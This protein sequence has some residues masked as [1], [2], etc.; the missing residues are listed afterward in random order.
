MKTVNWKIYLNKPPQVVY[1]FLSTAKGRKQF[2]AESAE[3]VNGVIHFKFPNGWE[4]LGKIIRQIQNEEFS[5]DYFDSKVTFRL[6][7][8][9]SGTDLEL[10]NEKV[11]EQEFEEVLSGWVSVLMC[12]KAAVD[13][14]VDLRNH[15]SNKTWDQG[16]INN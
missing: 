14:G 16:F 1:Q 6:V 3:E 5:V 8:S 7:A 2:W 10:I 4:Y 13:F 9:G 15:N 11:P 12:M